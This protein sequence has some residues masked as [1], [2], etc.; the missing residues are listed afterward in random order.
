M[1]LGSPL[2][3]ND[4]GKKNFFFFKVRLAVIQEVAF[5]VI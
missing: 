1:S 4:Q 5:D 3:S 2:V